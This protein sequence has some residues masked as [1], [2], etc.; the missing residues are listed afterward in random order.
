MTIRPFYE[1]RI[2]EMRSEE[3]AN[4]AIDGGLWLVGEVLAQGPTTSSDFVPDPLTSTNPGIGRQRSSSFT[5]S[6]RSSATGSSSR[7]S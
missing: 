7:D 1:P 3:Y 6:K 2:L 5:S 4:T